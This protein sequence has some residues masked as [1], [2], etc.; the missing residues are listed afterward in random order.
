MSN[1]MGVDIGYLIAEV[2]QYLHCA[3]VF[4]FLLRPY[5]YL[6]SIP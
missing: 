4:M 5:G 6:N 1:G 3:W 2:V